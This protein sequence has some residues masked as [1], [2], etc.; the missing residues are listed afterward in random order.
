LEEAE[1]KGMSGIEG[2]MMKFGIQALSFILSTCTGHI[3]AQIFVL[4]REG[5]H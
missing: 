1:G 3:E 2:G 4:K 5:G